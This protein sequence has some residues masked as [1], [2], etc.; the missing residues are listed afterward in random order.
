MGENRVFSKLRS[1]HL[2]ALVLIG[3]ALVGELLLVD[4]FLANQKKDGEIIN[5]AGRQRML[6]QRIVKGI[7]INHPEVEADISEWQ[8]R[9]VWLKDD[10][11]GNPVQ[12]DLHALDSLVYAL[13]RA[14]RDTAAG[15][16]QVNLLADEFLSGMDRIVDELSA[17]AAGKVDRVQTLDR[18]L[19]ALTLGLLLLVLLFI[20][21]PVVR[22]VRRQ[23]EHID[24]ERR[25]QEAAR[26]TAE[27]AVAEKEAT[28]QELYALYGTLDKVTLYAS[29]SRDGTVVHLNRQ[30]RDLLGTPA[31]VTGRPFAEI[32]NRQEERQ[33]RMAELLQQASI[34]PWRGQWAVTLASGEQRFLEL[35]ILP[36]RRTGGEVNFIVLATDVTEQQKSGE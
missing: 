2:L 31:P 33:L 7:A 30:F 10:L 29:L 22:L 11:E 35:C 18:W 36:T 20:F 23:Y 28:L 13:S 12:Q 19:T 1:A 14:A 17:A 4:G 26:H 32:L 27:E 24:S 34:T 5:V 25:A 9:H 21:P 16:E 15:V 3:L 6:S 8:A